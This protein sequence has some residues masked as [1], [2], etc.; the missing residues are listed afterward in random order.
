[1]EISEPPG[2]TLNPPQNDHPVGSVIWLVPLPVV[3]PKSLTG[4]PS[5]VTSTLTSAELRTCAPARPFCALLLLICAWTNSSLPGSRR[6]TFVEIRF[7]EL[8]ALFTG[9]RD[10]NDAAQLAAGR[11]FLDANAAKHI[12]RALPGMSWAEL[13]DDGRWSASDLYCS[14]MYG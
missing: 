10:P 13:Y 1:M 6:L 7:T 11:L 4:A 14:D 9:L 12:H 8:R 3:D 2:R 5:S